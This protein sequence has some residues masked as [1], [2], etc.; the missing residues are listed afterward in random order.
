LNVYINMIICEYS[1]KSY[2]IKGPDTKDH[3]EKLLELGAKYN[4]GLSTGAG[5]VISKT[6]LDAVKK[7]KLPIKSFEIKKCPKKGEEEKPKKKSPEKEEEKPKKKTVKKVSPE[8]K[9][10]KK[11]TKKVSPVKKTTAVK[12]KTVVEKI[13]PE[14]KPKKKV[15]KKRDITDAEIHKLKKYVRKIRNIVKKW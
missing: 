13:S 7:S 9:P 5:W 3:K 6:K 2:V 1:D 10:K 15:T 12:K 14:E 4:S 8:E 11:V